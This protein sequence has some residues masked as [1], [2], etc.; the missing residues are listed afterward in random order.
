MRGETNEDVFAVRVNG[1]TVNCIGRNEEECMG[2][3]VC[4]LYFEI[5][6]FY[7]KRTAAGLYIDHFEE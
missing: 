5:S 2:F 7:I 6:F 3:V 1:E 4:L